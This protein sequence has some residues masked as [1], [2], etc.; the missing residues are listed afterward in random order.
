MNVDPTSK[1]TVNVTP[2]P[3]IPASA[4]IISKFPASILVS[5]PT[6][7]SKVPILS[8]YPARVNLYL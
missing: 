6:T 4:T 7:I 5:I 3:P 8:L 2:T 1:P